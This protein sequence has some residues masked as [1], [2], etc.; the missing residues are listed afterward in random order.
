MK[1]HYRYVALGTSF[2][3]ASG[4]RPAS[5]APAHVLYDNELALDVGATCLGLAGE[6]RP[7]I[8]HHFFRPAG[9]FP[10]A[11]AAVLHCA[12]QLCARV[13]VASG[14]VW[15]VTHQEP[16]FDGLCSMY[17]ARQLLTGQ[18]PHDGWQEL[19]LDPAGWYER[20]GEINWFQPQVA[21]WKAERR[22]PALLAAYAAHVD[23]CRRLGCPP[24]RALHSLLYAALKRGRDF[25]R[26]GAYRFFRE[27]ALY[28]ARE[29]WQLNP[30]V[31][32]VLEDSAMF[33]P[34]RAFLDREL[35]AY[36]RDLR[37]ARRAIVY[38]PAARQPF[39]Q[40]F[41]AVAAQPLLDA[42]HQTQPLH[43]QP[44]EQALEPADGIYLRD[45]E[46]LLFKEWARQDQDQAPLGR[47]FTFTAIAYSHQRREAAVNDSD[48]YF[49]VDPERAGTCHLYSV[50]ARLQAEEVRCLA[51]ARK[52][53][54]GP[55]AAAGTAG[56]AEPADAVRCRPGF[57][58]RAGAEPAAFH[59]PWFDGH[60]YGC[61]IVVHPHRGTQIGAP[62]R[63]SDLRDDPVAE[64]VREQL[65][66]AVYRPPVKVRDVAFTPAA[67]ANAAEQAAS[68]SLAEFR[69]RPPRLAPGYLR[70]CYVALDD[71]VRLQAAHLGEQIG[72]DLWRLLD[73][74]RS[75][76]VPS[77]FVDR[78]LVRGPHGVLVWN[79]RGV[80]VACQP[81]Q[82]RTA[83]ALRD[84]LDTIAEVGRELRALAEAPL[85]QHT[86][87]DLL[88]RSEQ[89]LRAVV[90]LQDELVT[91]E[92]AVLRRLV[93]AVRLERSVS[94]VRD[95]NAA[96]SQ[97]LQNRRLGEN[98]EQ[99]TRV[100]RL[101]HLIEYV[102]VPTYLAEFWHMFMPESHGRDI[103]LV[104]IV[105]IGVVEA[106]NVCVEGHSPLLAAGKRIGQGLCGRR[107]GDDPGP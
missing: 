12:A 55:W 33:A 91:P 83:D 58:G 81:D 5:A 4:P 76:G 97:R 38:L 24:Q 3:A 106:F 43:L 25:G 71:S 17:L 63:R 79:R 93:E 92:G 103:L 100:Q 19:G 2:S 50:W 101:V 10:A 54:G 89:L 46:C 28:L 39:G 96:A 20:A 73:P 56:P 14:E 94:A 41:P 18:V 98:L 30:L 40:W 16:D 21:A 104:A 49:A 78:H 84:R 90:R 60:N 61:T 37:R 72:R 77:D 42:A 88:E 70:F 45:P 62:G 59:D 52:A 31:D 67:Q 15:L 32:S 66:L 80:A 9:Q 35:A 75:T 87:Q 53:S 6:P 44:T 51:A 86:Y 95:M 8:D 23:Q 36:E 1:F 57:E 99:V 11:A 13:Q 27:V 34:E 82:E 107:G 102:L 85:D 47:G 22:V 69:Q 29:D 64:L 7:V 48:Y 74:E 68:L 26:D 105:G 65:E